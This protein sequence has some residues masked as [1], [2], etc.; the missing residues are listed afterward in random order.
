MIVFDTYTRKINGLFKIRF[1]KDLP[2]EAYLIN[3]QKNNCN[4]VICNNTVYI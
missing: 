3:F 4:F 2:T 1:L